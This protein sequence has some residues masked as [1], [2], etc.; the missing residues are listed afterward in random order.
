[1]RHQSNSF[2]HPQNLLRISLI[3]TNKKTL[4]INSQWSPSPVLLDTGATVSLLNSATWK[5][6]FSHISSPTSL[7]GYGNYEIDI[8]VYSCQCARQ[9]MLCQPFT[10]CVACFGANLLSNKPSFSQPDPTSLGIHIMAIHIIAAVSFNGLACLLTFTHQPQ[11]GTDV[12]SVV[13]PLLLLIIG[14]AQQD[15]I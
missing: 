11:V 3:K 1:M 15:D 8:A 13:Q 2:F 12:S 6:F 14:P 5:H 9:E 4:F 10:F 7:H